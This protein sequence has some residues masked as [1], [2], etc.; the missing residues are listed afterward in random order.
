VKASDRV[1]LANVLAVSLCALVYELLCGTLA[2]YL[3][4]DAVREFSF[5]LGTYLFAMGVGAWI[6]KRFEP[7]AAARYVEAE[8]ALAIV[9]GF[10]VPLLL[11]AVAA[12]LPLRPVL[13]GVVGVIGVLVGLELPLLVRILRERGHGGDSGGDGSAGGGGRVFEE[14]VARALAFDYVGA[15]GAS[16]LF[17]LVLV[18]YLGLVRTGIVTGVVNAA[19]ALLATFVLDV[20][21]A[22]AR[23]AASAMAIAA[24]GVAFFRAE[25]WVA[26]ATD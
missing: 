15:L 4:G 24:L 21:R 11:V 17:P 3:L 16:I 19:V 23:R 2:S 12:H 14:T 10:A 18:P 8:I 22:N 13:Y 5:V 26:G 6:S 20:S 9:G 1:L 7:R 25:G